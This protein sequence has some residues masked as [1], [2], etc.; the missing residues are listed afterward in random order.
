MKTIIIAAGKGQR[1]SDEF[2]DI[3]KSLIPI[4]DETIFDRQ[5]KVFKNKNISNIVVIT[6]LKII[7]GTKIIN[8]WF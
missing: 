7:K 4:N 1:I 6:G 5:K 3:P 2:K 8:K